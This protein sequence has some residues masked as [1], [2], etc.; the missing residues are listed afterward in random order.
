MTPELA[1]F[2]VSDYVGLC[3]QHKITASED[4]AVAVIWCRNRAEKEMVR[5]AFGKITG[6]PRKRPRREGDEDDGRSE[7]VEVEPVAGRQGG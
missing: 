6:R 2:H 3:A 1:E 5:A 4:G 7:L